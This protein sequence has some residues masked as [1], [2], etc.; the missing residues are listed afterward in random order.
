MFFEISRMEISRKNRG[1]F[2]RTVFR[3]ALELLMC[4]SE[5]EFWR[6]VGLN[7]QNNSES[8]CILISFVI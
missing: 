1:V 7:A 6:K 4:V 8:Y 5:T 3:F 2:R